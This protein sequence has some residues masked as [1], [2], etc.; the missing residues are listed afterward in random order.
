MLGL[1]WPSWILHSDALLTNIHCQSTAP[2]GYSLSQVSVLTQFIYLW[3][4][5]LTLM[6]SS[7][8]GLTLRTKELGAALE[9]WPAG[10]FGLVWSSFCSIT[11]VPVW[12]STILICKCIYAENSSCLL[13]CDPAVQDRV[14]YHIHAIDYS[15]YFLAFNYLAE[16]TCCLSDFC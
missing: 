15:I 6:T 3:C 1:L 9:A 7:C 10:L 8:I 4:Y 2:S 14:A 13:H 11:I 12:S 5:D 16:V